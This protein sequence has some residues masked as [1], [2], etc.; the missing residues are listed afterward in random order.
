MKNRRGSVLCRCTWYMAHPGSFRE[1][2]VSFS[3]SAATSASCPTFAI[4]VTAN[5]TIVL[6]LRRGKCAG[7]AILGFLC[8]RLQ[9]SNEFVNQDGVAAVRPGRNHSRLGSRFF[10]DKREI[11]A[12]LLWKLFVVGNA[13]G[14]SLPARQLLV[15]AFDLVVSTGMRGSLV[16]LLA[17]N[18]VADADRNFGQL[19]EHVELGDDQPRSAVD[20]AGVAEQ[21]QIEPASAPRTSGHCAV[22]VAAFAEIVAGI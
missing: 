4:Q 14:R 1:C 10:L 15:N 8:G 11:G 6:L 20:H 2:S 22:F 5:T 17:V 13:F 9:L 12:R 18:L 3:K 19:V 21:R 16:C 7:E